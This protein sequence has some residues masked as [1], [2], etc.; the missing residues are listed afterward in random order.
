[1]KPQ[2][3]R[4][5]VS[6]EK[7]ESKKHTWEEK[8]FEDELLERTFILEDCGDSCEN[9]IKGLKG[10]KVI[11]SDTRGLKVKELDN[12]GYYIFPQETIMCEASN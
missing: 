4:I 11:L 7:T 6:Q 8:T 5:L 2:F 12:T 1:M 9:D 10:K 3:R